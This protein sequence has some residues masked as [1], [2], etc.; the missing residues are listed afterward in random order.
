M[1]RIIN[2]QARA[3][4]EKERDIPY[5]PAR[6]VFSVLLTIFEILLI[7]GIVVALCYFVPYFYV[8]ALLTQ[9]GCALHLVASDDSPDYKVPWLF[10]VLIFPIVGFMLYFLFYSRKLKGKFIRRLSNLSKNTYVNDDTDAFIKLQAE[11]PQAYS[12]AKMI[13]K[14][15]DT[16]LFENTKQEYFGSGEK[17]FESMIEELKQAK[18]FIYMEYFIIEKG[19]LWSSILSILVEKV[20]EGVEVKI[21]YD[22]IGCMTKLPGNYCK[23]L[24]RYGIQAVHF[25]RLRGGADS[26]FNNRN[27]RKITIIDGKVAYTGGVNIADEYINEVKLFGHWKDG[28]IRIEGKAVYEFTELFT[29]DYGISVKK[30]P[31]YNDELYPEMN[32]EAKGYVLPFG[33]GPKPIYN[34]SIAK[35]VIQNMLAVATKYVYITTP[36]LIIDNDLCMSLENAALRGVSVKIILPHIPDKKT[37]FFLSR[38]LYPRLI[39]AGVEIFEYQNGF[40]HAKN[41]IVDGYYAMIG[42]INMDYRSLAHHFENGVWMYGTDSIKSAEED[43]N[44]AL[45]DSLKM[46]PEMVAVGPIKKFYRA[47][48]KIFAPL[49]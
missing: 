17:F 10:F 2:Y 25:S 4:G 32:V 49:F 15:A 29:L 28:G 39:N 19:K 44:L 40:I 7:I 26:E 14:L 6:Y 23:I 41:Y 12:H 5:V 48:L 47:V 27:H 8:C 30:M 33:A 38:S 24:K 34:K 45:S 36:Y 1:K 11:N 3:L 22:D 37:V 20:K 31:T 35:S 46:T 42:T 9:I 16:H 43:F 13:C 21:V 18:K